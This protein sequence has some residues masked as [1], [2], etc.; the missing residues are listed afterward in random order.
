MGASP[1]PE[2]PSESPPERGK[3]KSRGRGD[4]FWSKE[5]LCRFLGWIGKIRDLTSEDLFEL[6]FVEDRDV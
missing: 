2:T 3:S 1:S 4:L 6:V 5:L